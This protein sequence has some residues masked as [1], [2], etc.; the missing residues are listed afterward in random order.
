[1]DEAG[2]LAQITSAVY[3]GGY[4]IHVVFDDGVEA[5]IDLEAE[6]FG[7][8]FEPLKD[9][10][11][12]RQFAMDSELNTIRWPSGADFA[13]EFLYEQ[14]ARRAAAVGGAPGRP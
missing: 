3:V 1:M 10:G 8:V 2:R 5:D 12:F 13:P 11:L 4:V 7:E 14:A 6:L 9:P